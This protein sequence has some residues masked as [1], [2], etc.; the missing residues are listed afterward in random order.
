MAW[1]FALMIDS[2]ASDIRRNDFSDTFTVID[3]GGAALRVGDLSAQRG[4]GIFESLGVIDGH[5]QEVEP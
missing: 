1:R 2:V 5:V 3:P 4:D